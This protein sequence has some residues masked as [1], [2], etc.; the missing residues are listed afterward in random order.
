MINPEA[1]ELTTAQ[2][3]DVDLI[4]RQLGQM[5]R[6]LLEAEFVKLVAYSYRQVNVTNALVRQAASGER[7][8]MHK[9]AI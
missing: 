3:F 4:R 8:A 1:F 2:E 9:G 5:P 7:H 6:E